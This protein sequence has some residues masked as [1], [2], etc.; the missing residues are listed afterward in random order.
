MHV[1]TA[2]AA[3]ALTAIFSNI[4]DGAASRAKIPATRPA[5]TP[6]TI[7]ATIPASEIVNYEQGVTVNF[8]GKL[9]CNGIP[10]AQ[11]DLAVFE[12][13]KPATSRRIRTSVEGDY[14]ITFSVNSPPPWTLVIDAGEFRATL[15][16]NS[17]E[18]RN[19]SWPLEIQAGAVDVIVNFAGTEPC[20]AAMYLW[21][22]DFCIFNEWHYYPQRIWNAGSVLRFPRV[23][24][25]DYRIVCI[26]ESPAAAATA[27][28][29]FTVSGR[30]TNAAQKLQIGR[31]AVLRFEPVNEDGSTLA[32][33]FVMTP[34]YDPAGVAGEGQAAIPGRAQLR[35]DHRGGIEVDGLSPGK[36]KIYFFPD[37]GFRE[38]AMQMITLPAEPRCEIRWTIRPVRRNASAIV[39]EVSLWKQYTLDPWYR[40]DPVPWKF[41]EGPF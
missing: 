3:I 12:G 40:E 28:P 41:R 35:I 11:A 1:S 36:V 7:P 29:W 32:G 14:D 2:G 4:Q 26:P 24:A 21:R 22:R 37:D 25:G 38:P 19:R 13:T 23:A 6:A 15:P 31:G 18:A 20:D 33:L 9:L 27:T 34:A 5:T 30:E 8:A 16:L 10:V 17:R 39:E